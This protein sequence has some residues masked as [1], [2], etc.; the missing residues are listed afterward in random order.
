M[1]EMLEIILKAIDDKKGE[2]TVYFDFTAVNPFIDY[3]VITSASNLRQ[4]YA[5]ASNVDDELSKHGIQIR[6]FEGDK[7]SRWILVDTGSIT[8]HV[9]L[10]EER[11]FYSLEKL[12]AHLPK[13]SI[14]VQ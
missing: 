6:S 5:I 4:V 13:G 12:Y 9:F 1:N 2:D 10:H 7:D 3:A 11:E 8:V 14:N